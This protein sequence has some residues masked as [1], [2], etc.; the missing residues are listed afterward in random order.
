MNR[1]YKV[2]KT[3]VWCVIGVFLGVT[4]YTCWD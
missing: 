1:L 4:G 3:A 2:L